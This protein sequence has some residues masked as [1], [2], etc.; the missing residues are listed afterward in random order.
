MAVK[1]RP[2]GVNGVF[3]LQRWPWGSKDFQKGGLGWLEKYVGVSKRNV[4]GN[5]AGD[6]LGM[7][8]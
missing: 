1:N 6:L 5:S 3:W 2:S 4:P 8:K 7:V